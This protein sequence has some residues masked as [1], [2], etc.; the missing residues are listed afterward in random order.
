ME[1]VL[2]RKVF[3]ESI[4]IAKL[5]HT[6]ASIFEKEPMASRMTDLDALCEKD[7]AEVAAGPKKIADVESIGED[8]DEDSAEKQ[9]AGP[10]A[11]NPNLGCSEDRQIQGARKM[12]YDRLVKLFPDIADHSAVA[13]LLSET[14]LGGPIHAVEEDQCKHL[15]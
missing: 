3:D 7:N 11:A 9:E 8:H 1:D 15:V 2:F 13:A 10:S 6:I 12:K 4:K 14:N 5:S